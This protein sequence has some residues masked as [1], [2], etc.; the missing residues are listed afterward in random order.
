MTTFQEGD[1]V[2]TMDENMTTTSSDEDISLENDDGDLQTTLPNEEGLNNKDVT[3]TYDEDITLKND[4][5]DVKTTFLEVAAP[6]VKKHLVPMALPGLG[7]VLGE[8]KS[9]QHCSRWKCIKLCTSANLNLAVLQRFFNYLNSF[10]AEPV[11]SGPRYGSSR[12]EMFFYLSNNLF[13]LKVQSK[14][15]FDFRSTSVDT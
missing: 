13:T 4:D 11:L 9:I 1:E 2:K 3:T 5:E 15:I 12:Q 10:S 8:K 7:E 6:E 14:K